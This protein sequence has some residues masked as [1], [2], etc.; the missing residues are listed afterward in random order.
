M[1]VDMLLGLYQQS[2]HAGGQESLGVKMEE[3]ERKAEYCLTAEIANLIL[4]VSDWSTPQ[5]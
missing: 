3:E 4:S 5:V 1:Q 2:H